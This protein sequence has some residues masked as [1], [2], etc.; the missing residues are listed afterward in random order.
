MTSSPKLFLHSPAEAGKLAATLHAGLGQ[1]LVGMAMLAKS[2]ANA[3]AERHDPEEERARLLQD[4][5]AGSVVKVDELIRWL[6]D[7]RPR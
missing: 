7:G 5:L 1:S 6:D 4:L 2:H 3:L